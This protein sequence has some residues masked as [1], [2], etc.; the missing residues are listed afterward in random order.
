MEEFSPYGMSVF[1]DAID[2]IQS[3]DLAYDAIWIGYTL[4]DTFTRD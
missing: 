2:V 3:V 4:W 1:E